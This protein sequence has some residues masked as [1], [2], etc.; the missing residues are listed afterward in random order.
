MDPHADLLERVVGEL[1]IRTGALR[2]VADETGIPYDT[3]LRVKN[4]EGDPGYSKVRALAAYLFPQAAP[5]LPA[6]QEG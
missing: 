6:E 2:R 3:V 4:R 5:A 1:E